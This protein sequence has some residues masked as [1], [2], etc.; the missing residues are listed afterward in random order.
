M[1]LSVLDLR[2]AK[3]LFY[4]HVYLDCAA[5]CSVSTCRGRVPRTAAY[6]AGPCAVYSY[7][8]IP[9][10]AA[11]AAAARAAGTRRLSRAITDIIMRWLS[12]EDADP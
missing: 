8:S 2:C 5:F 7:N 9:A 10:R 11:T 12:R 6:G 1:P 4:I 3:M